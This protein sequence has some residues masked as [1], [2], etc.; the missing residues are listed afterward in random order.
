MNNVFNHKDNYFLNAGD[1]DIPA[2][3]P[4]DILIEKGESVRLILSS[5]ISQEH[6]SLTV[7]GDKAWVP[8]RSGKKVWIARAETVLVNKDNLSKYI[9]KRGR[10]TL[11]PVPFV[12]KIINFFI[13]M[14]IKVKSKFNKKEK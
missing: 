13:K 8:G 4:G 7:F 11:Y 3:L 6:I 12:Q 14:N 9:I 10:D 1:V 2:P 5:E